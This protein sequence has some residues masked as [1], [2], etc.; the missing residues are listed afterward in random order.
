[1]R[2]ILLSLLVTMPSF[3]VVTSVNTTAGTYTVDEWG[4][5]ELPKK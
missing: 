4:Y 1:M 3:A 2:Y 5:F